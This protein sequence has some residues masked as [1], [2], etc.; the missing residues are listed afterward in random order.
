MMIRANNRLA[1][2]SNGCKSSAQIIRHPRYWTRKKKG[3]RASVI[4]TV[5]A[6]FITDL[7]A[8]EVH[9]LQIQWQYEGLKHQNLLITINFCELRY[10]STEHIG[11]TQLGF[12]RPYNNSWNGL[13]QQQQSTAWLQFQYLRHYLQQ[14]R[15]IPMHDIPKY[16]KSSFY[17]NQRQVQKQQQ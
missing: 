13:G 5:D 11:S 2:C 14:K 8:V 4:V 6:I 17:G 7:I 3:E 1:A 16:K 9:R 10:E 15:K 12:E